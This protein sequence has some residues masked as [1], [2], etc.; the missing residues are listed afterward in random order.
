MKTFIENRARWQWLSVVTE[1]VESIPAKSLTWETK[2]MGHCFH[3]ETA[4]TAEEV[5]WDDC[6][7]Q[8]MVQDFQFGYVKLKDQRTAGLRD[9]Q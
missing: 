3:L 1:Q 5:L 6:P 4:D 2:Q 8:R 7:K 9:R